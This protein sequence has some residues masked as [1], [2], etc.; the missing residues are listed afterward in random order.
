MTRT[1]DQHVRVGRSYTRARRFPWVIGKIQGWTI[2]LGPYTATQLG[3]LIGGLYLLIKTFD[4]WRR[5]GVLAVVVIALP[6]AATWAVRH[7]HIDGR[8]PLRALGG[9]AALLTE[10]RCGRIGGRP[11]RDPRPATLGG[12]V[13]LSALPAPRPAP[14]PAVRQPVQQPAVQ[15]PAVQQP[16]VQ[17]P[18]V[19]QPAVRQPAVPRAAV[20]PAPTAL[21]ALLAASAEKASAGK[22]E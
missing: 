6:F 5:L 13:R 1:A 14:R 17:Q 9:M 21:Q 18:A 19:Q 20:R 7:A 8:T 12:G 22:E 4:L 11:A 15:Q 3:V 2:P 16:A 10:P